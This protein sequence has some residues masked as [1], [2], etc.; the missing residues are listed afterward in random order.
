MYKKIKISLKNMN[1]TTEDIISYRDTVKEDE[2][3]YITEVNNQRVIERAYIASYSFYPED[4]SCN[5][6]IIKHDVLKNFY[7]DDLLSLLSCIATSFSI[8]RDDLT[9]LPMENI[10]KYLNKEEKNLFL[11]RSPRSSADE[12]YH[13]TTIG[14]TLNKLRLYNFAFIDGMVNCPP[15]YLIENRD[16]ISFA[17]ENKIA[18]AYTIYKNIKHIKGTFTTFSRT[19]TSKEFMMYYLQVILALNIALEECGFTHYDLNS[20]NVVLQEVE[21]KNFTLPYNFSNKIIY[22]LSSGCI[23]T[24]INFSSAHV[25]L[26]DKDIG[27]IIHISRMGKKSFLSHGIYRDR[28][29]ILIDVYKL[30]CMSLYEMYRY[31]NPAFNE[32]SPILNYFNKEETAEEIMEK[33]NKLYFFLPHIDEFNMEDF[34]SFCISYSEDQGWSDL[35]VKD[36][37]RLYTPSIKTFIEFHDEKDVE[38]VTKNSIENI[39]NAI[40]EEDIIIS[41]IEEKVNSLNSF[42]PFRLPH[43]LLFRQEV[44]NKAKETFKFYNTYLSL[45]DRL[46]AHLL[47]EELLKEIYNIDKTK[48]LYR[49]MK[50]KVRELH[51]YIREDLLI[52][53]KT[54]D[55][56]KEKGEKIKDIYNWYF[57]IYA[58]LNYYV[59]L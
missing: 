30:L 2:D 23:S 15:Q 34:I 22:L 39:E 3:S 44:L 50:K 42:I 1:I 25:Q 5:E 35:F 41:S 48:E 28:D 29:N 10:R 45:Y 19:C 17:V 7:K 46:R 37:D 6:N 16:I 55:E 9:L 54:K 31:D 14:F 51:E 59:P 24:I 38:N 40:N 20:D 49:R 12:I 47:S 8:Y 11:L 52:L 27:D 18:P 32:L 33:Q 4:M 53:I 21:E 56:I 58:S 26:I 36:N 43:N 13:E 57:N